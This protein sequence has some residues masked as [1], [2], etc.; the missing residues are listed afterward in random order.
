MMRRLPPSPP[1]HPPQLPPEAYEAEFRRQGLLPPSPEI[2][3]EEY[4]VIEPE[5]EL[6]D[7]VVEQESDAER[8]ADA[9]EVRYLDLVREV[10]EMEESQEWDQGIIDIIKEWIEENPIPDF[11]EPIPYLA[12]L[13][14][15]TERLRNVIDDMKERPYARLIE[16]PALRRRRRTVVEARRRQV[17]RKVLWDWLKITLSRIRRRRALRNVSFPLADIDDRRT[18]LRYISYRME[19]NPLLPEEEEEIPPEELPEGEPRILHGIIPYFTTLYDVI[20]RGLRFAAHQGYFPP[21]SNTAGVAIN[22]EWISQSETV[23]VHPLHTFWLREHK[24]I[25]ET[26]DMRDMIKRLAYGFASEIMLYQQRPSPSPE[27]IIQLITALRFYITDRTDIQLQQPVARFEEITLEIPEE[28]GLCEEGRAKKVWIHGYILYSAKGKHGECFFNAVRQSLKDSGCETPH[29][30]NIMVRANKYLENVDK[31]PLDMGVPLNRVA[32]FTSFLAAD[33]TVS[34]FNDKNELYP[35]IHTEKGWPNR[36][37]LVLLEGHYYKL[38]GQGTEKRAKGKQC[39][40]CHNYFHKI[41]ECDYLQCASCGR[42]VKELENHVCNLLNTNFWSRLVWQ[43]Q[44]RKKLFANITFEVKNKCLEDII[45]FD[46][47]TYPHPATKRHQVYAVGWLWEGIYR[48]TYGENA[49]SEFVDWLE[50][51]GNKGDKFILIGYNNAYFDN[52]LLLT[53]NIKRRIYT[54]IIMHEGG[55]LICMKWKSKREVNFRCID[56][57]R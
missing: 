31:E 36:A 34:M 16:E 35:V 45:I 6:I 28:F 38:V 26:A 53:E 11:I 44:G 49:V 50:S 43:K 13:R 18:D 25:R 39:E 2:E 37:Q 17:A 41:H 21:V 10:Q 56:L 20:Q 52:H 7:L 5:P 32:D 12:A 46:F 40:R 23:D 48:F 22:V 8:R 29:G 24:F 54:K 14:D 47:E 19:I 4:E 3:P 27:Y 30:H 15:I 9:Y 51:R 1:Y 55:G 33:I 57:L 42:W